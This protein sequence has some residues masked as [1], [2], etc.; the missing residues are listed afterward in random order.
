M[1]LPLL[2]DIHAE[3]TEV[4]NGVGRTFAK[5]CSSGWG[6]RR[7]IIA[8]LRGA[9]GAREVPVIGGAAPEDSATSFALPI[10]NEPRHVFV[11]AVRTDQGVQTTTTG[12][13]SISWY[14]DNGL[15]QIT[16]VFGLTNGTKYTLRLAVLGEL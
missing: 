11:T 14:W 2:R 5:E 9:L 12:P 16:Q 3:T 6:E 7:Q 15:V 13:V 10:S 4:V 1:T 8:R